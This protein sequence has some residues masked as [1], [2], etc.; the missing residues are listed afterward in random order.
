MPVAVAQVPNLYAIPHPPVG[1]LDYRQCMEQMSIAYIR[2]VAA[3][4][5]FTAEVLR[6]DFNGVD[7][8]IGCGS[9]GRRIERGS[10]NI[11]AKSTAKRRKRRGV[12]A[13]SYSTDRDTWEELASGDWA[14]PVILVVVYLPSMQHK[15][16]AKLSPTQLILRGQAFW[17]SLRGM[18]C[19]GDWPTVSMAWAQPFT[20][21]QLQLVMQ[22]IMAGGLP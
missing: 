13:W 10:L 6:Q 14:N 19:P 5:G 22:R 8:K 15:D 1:P 21:S 17:T 16:W 11:Q 12:D 4:S 18:P 20:P 2:A 7:M 9:P 3:V